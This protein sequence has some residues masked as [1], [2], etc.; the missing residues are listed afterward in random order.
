VAATAA[1]L[2]WWGGAQHAGDDA[3][4]MAGAGSRFA[5]GASSPAS[6]AKGAS[7]R[8]RRFGN[9]RQAQPIT[10]GVVKTSD[11]RVVLDAI[12]NI[13]ALNTAV[14]RSRVDGELKNI[15]FKE[16]QVV[17]AGALLAD[18]DPRSLEIQLAQSQGQLA[19]DQA[20]LKNAQLDLE[21]YKDLLGK[22]SISK[23]Q[24]DTQ[25][26]LVRQLTGTVQMVQ[27]QADNAKLQ[28]SYTKITAPV[29]GRLGLK[30]A[31]LGSVIRAGDATG[32]VTITQTQPIGVVFAV[33]ENKLPAIQRKLQANEVLTV[34]A[35]DRDQRTLL[36]SG[37]VIATDNAIDPLTGTI[38]LKATFANDKG[39]LFPNQFVNIR[40]QVDV[41]EDA[42]TIPSAAV[43]RGAQGTFVYVVKSDNTVVMRNIQLGTT[44]GNVVSVQGN[45]QPGDKVVTDGADRLRDG[46]Q[47]E[48]ITPARTDG[49]RKPKPASSAAAA[50]VA[51][52]AA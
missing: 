28:L 51:A 26:A 42:L 27:A 12:G 45:L 1:A 48:I 50:A 32:I 44:E 17:K 19:R 29:S 25:E 13:S 11:V 8:S 35:W 38:K 15:R 4:A 39:T 31:E 47:I 18:I 49:A 33:P 6:A 37:K 41:L 2:G 22:D 7:E 16:G 52:S 46:S 43:Q 20:Q 21:R 36:A 9:D 24:V 14:V 40:L 34:Q 5:F 3:Q 10:A 23:Q 30:T